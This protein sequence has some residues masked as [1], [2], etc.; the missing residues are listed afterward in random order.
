[1]R[2]VVGIL[3]DIELRRLKGVDFIEARVCDMGCIGGI[4][5]A[6]SSFLSR[7]KVENFGFDRET[8]KERMEELEELYRAGI[9]RLQQQVRP[10]EQI[11]LG[12]DVARA[13]EK[14]SELQSVYAE[15]PHLD[16]GT[17]GRPTCRVMA[18]DIV[19][20]EAS[21]DDCIFRLREKM[22]NLSQELH[23]LS[24]RLVHTMTPEETE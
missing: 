22:G 15:L 21:L 10:I 1:M 2:S 9:W 11:P 13:M 23:D 3:Q 16:C 8:D 5:N 17:C 24:K 6:E 19:R 4:A 14:L 20:G 18:E 7:L 12:K